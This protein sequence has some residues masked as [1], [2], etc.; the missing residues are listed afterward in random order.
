[1]KT[2]LVDEQIR[3]L[4]KQLKIPTFANYSDLIRRSAPDSNISDILL[5]LMKAEYEQRQWNQNQR[6]LKQ[7]GFP[8][9]KT[10][11]ELD[12]TRYSGEISEIFVNELASCKFISE[13]RNITMLGNPGRG[14]THMAIGLGLEACSQ[15]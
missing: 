5:M 4:S 12:L 11:D 10:L 14:K 13:H 15:G 2:L 7:A 8:F 3:L 6:R 9:T 1:M